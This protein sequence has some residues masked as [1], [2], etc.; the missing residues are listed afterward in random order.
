MEGDSRRDAERNGMQR[1]RNTDDRREEKV[2]IS[3]RPIEG[4]RRNEVPVK[5]KTARKSSL[6]FGVV[7]PPPLSEARKV[8]LKNCQNFQ[9]NFFF[10]RKILSFIKIIKGNCLF[11][12]LFKTLIFTK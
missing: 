6:V 10:V 4:S 7:I 2:A 3:E 8:F 9:K 11:E 5:K 1:M 12:T